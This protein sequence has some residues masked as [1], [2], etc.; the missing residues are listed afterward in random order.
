MSEVI[1]D[2]ECP[3][4]DQ[5]LLNSIS[6]YLN[7]HMLTLVNVI[8]IMFFTFVM[9]TFSEQMLITVKMGTRHNNYKWEMRMCILDL[10]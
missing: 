2:A 5:S 1:H 7:S 9:T 8:K 4:W 3:N 6:S 10:Y